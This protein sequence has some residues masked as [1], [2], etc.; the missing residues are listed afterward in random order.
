MQPS[1]VAGPH[2]DEALPLLQQY[3]PGRAGQAARATHP[4]QHGPLLVAHQALRRV[5]RSVPDLGGGGPAGP[6][7]HHPRR[8]CWCCSRCSPP[9][10]PNNPKQRTQPAPHARRWTS[11]CGRPT[12]LDGDGQEAVDR[13]EGGGQGGIL[14]RQRR[15]RARLG[16]AWVQ[17]HRRRPRPHLLQQLLH[18]GHLHACAG[19]RVGWVRW[20][21]GTRRGA[22]AAVV[23]GSHGR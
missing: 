22:G 2:L 7:P 17:H 10:P 13:L 1:L 4:A 18:Q 14:A 11:S 3:L 16:P 19:R 20:S 12:H 8:W 21:V 5:A 15:L 23:Q 6:A 9:P